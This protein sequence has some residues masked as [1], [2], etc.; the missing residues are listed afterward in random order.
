M[1]IKLPYH[2]FSLIPISEY[3]LAYWQHHLKCETEFNMPLH[4]DGESSILFITEGVIFDIMKE[5][6]RNPSP[7]FIVFK[8]DY[9]GGVGDQFAVKVNGT[10]IEKSGSINEMLKELG[11][12]STIQEQVYVKTGLDQFDLLGLGKHR[13][14]PNYLYEKYAD[15]CEEHDL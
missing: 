1:Q 11:V 4:A 3:Y 8:T 10:T 15:L 7:E 6:T 9:F 14:G 5:I 12:N 2:P 13:S